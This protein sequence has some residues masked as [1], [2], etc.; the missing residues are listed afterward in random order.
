MY[1][2]GQ[3]F[4]L[5]H[6]LLI[7]MTTEI[8]LIRH[9]ETEWSLSGQ[10]TGLT[11]IPLTK[12]GEQQARQLEERLRGVSFTEVLSSPLQR[13]RH[14]CELSGFGGKARI[15]SKLSEWDYG[16]YEG[17]TSTDIRSD[18]PAWKLYQDGCPG[19]ES[20]AQFCSRVDTVLADIRRREGRIAIF[21]HGHFLRALAVRWIDLR[22]REARCFSL[23]PA[24]ISRLAYEHSAIDAPVITTWNVSSENFH[25]M[26]P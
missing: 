26:N 16:D 22:I 17:R 9:G 15:E 13:A 6:N 8:Y 18:R 2:K 23:D 24:S 1:N 4:S 20:V 3:L 14:T 11:D 5:W 19:G 10:H 21:S 25:G 12:Q 7:I